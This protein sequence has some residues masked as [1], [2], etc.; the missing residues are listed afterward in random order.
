VRPAPLRGP[1]T[2]PLA[3]MLRRGAMLGFFALLTIGA[4]SV[5]TPKSQC[6]E[7]LAAVIP[8]AKKML[9]EHGE[10]YPFGASV[11][12]NG[13]IVQAAAYDGREHPPSEPLIDLLRQAFRADA[14]SGAIIASATVYDV[15]TIPPG[16][17]T[18]TD[19]VA[20]ELDHRDNYSVVV[21]YPYTVSAGAVQF[22]APFAH[23]GKFEIFAKHGG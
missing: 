1:S 6:E 17:S 11:K 4:A 10:F 8:F 23:Q 21:M 22:A 13:E 7:L 18:K 15:R 2:P 16:S 19:A 12:A 3:A 5:P 9:S 14:K 20:V